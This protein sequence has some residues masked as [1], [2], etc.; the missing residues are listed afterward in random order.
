MHLGQD[1]GAVLVKKGAPKLSFH[2]EGGGA[3]APSA[4]LNPPL[5]CQSIPARNQIEPRID[6]YMFSIETEAVPSMLLIRLKFRAKNCSAS[7][8]AAM[9]HTMPQCIM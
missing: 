5:I 2:R 1:K 9:H 6:V 8:H 3:V 7:Y 4:L